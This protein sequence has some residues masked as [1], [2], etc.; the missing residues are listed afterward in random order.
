MPDPRSKLPP[1][2]PVGEG[3]AAREKRWSPPPHKTGAEKREKGRSVNN[4]RVALKLQSA[5]G[6]AEEMATQKTA[7]AM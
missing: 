1:V 6:S 3:K 2:N 7:L 5:L 4:A